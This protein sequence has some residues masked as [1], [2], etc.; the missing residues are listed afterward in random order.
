M[1]DAELIHPALAAVLLGLKE[2]TLRNWRST[3]RYRLPYVKV[4][5]R[6]MYRR[7]DLDAFIERRTL[8]PLDKG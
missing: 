1:G 3:G 8:T 4:G 7:C 5:R 6:V 2:T